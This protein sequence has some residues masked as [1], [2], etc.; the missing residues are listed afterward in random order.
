MNKFDQNVTLLD[1]VK[2]KFY[3]D[4]NEKFFEYLD[5]R[6]LNNWMDFAKSLRDYE[7]KFLGDY[8]RDYELVGEK[9]IPLELSSTYAVCMEYLGLLSRDEK[10]YSSQRGG[11]WSC[12]Y[13]PTKKKCNVIT[14]RDV[15]DDLM[16][17][18]Q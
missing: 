13:D 7:A 1:Y 6:D 18:F 11:V 5:N 16:T 2:G 17:K 14:V 9:K 4:Q 8:V 10:E 12:N 3:S 15:L